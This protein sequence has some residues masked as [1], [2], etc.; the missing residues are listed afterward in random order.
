[1]CHN[2]QI[3]VFILCWRFNFSPF[4][5]YIQSRINSTRDGL[6]LEQEWGR[7]EFARIFI[8]SLDNIIFYYILR[9]FCCCTAEPAVRYSWGLNYSLVWEMFIYS[10][11]SPTQTGEGGTR[12]NLCLLPSLSPSPA[13][14][15]LLKQLPFTITLSTTNVC[16]WAGSE[17]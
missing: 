8:F 12:E 13:G 14:F 15:C 9:P 16:P 3:T 17:L 1:M 5:S 2:P 7:V 11:Q 6:T 10:T 4:Q